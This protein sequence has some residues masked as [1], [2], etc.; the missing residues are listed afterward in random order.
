M[1]TLSKLK[2]T[3]MMMTF[4]A[5]PSIAYVARVCQVNYTTAKRYMVQDE[6]EAA[7]REFTQSLV[8]AG[9]PSL[10]EVRT[11]I[12]TVANALLTEFRQD[13]ATGK[14]KCQSVGDFVALAQFRLFIRG[15]P[16]ERLAVGV[17]PGGKSVLE[18]SGDELEDGA[19]KYLDEA[20]HYRKALD[21]IEKGN[22]SRN[23][24]TKAIEAEVVPAKPEKGGK[25][26]S[27]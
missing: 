4:I 21:R 1:R 17:L 18:A 15:E 11:E 16:S 23:G 22:G 8:E 5:V 12:D 24:G 10:E 14:I 13:V 26:A 19:T 25:D 27:P 2:R 6:W 20:D 3:K 9:L 7:E